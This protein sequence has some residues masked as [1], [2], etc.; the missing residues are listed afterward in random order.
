MVFLL[1]TKL[2][3]TLDDHSVMGL[4]LAQSFFGAIQPQGTTVLVLILV[5]LLF[6]S[7]VLAGA[8]V[9]FFSLTFKDINL[10]K[11]KQQPAYKRIVDL[12]EQPKILLASLLI[13]N[14]FINISIII[15]SN[16]LID[17]M[18]NFEQFDAAWVEF[19]IKVIAVTFLLVLFG[20]IMPKVLATQNNVRFAKDFGGIVYG[21]SYV[22]MG[23][24]KPLVK[25]SDII[26]RKLANKS[27]SAYSLEE[28]DHAID[29]TTNETASENE[30]NILKSI[31]KFR[32]I[33]V[34]QIMKTRMDVSGVDQ[35]I[36]FDQLIEFVREVNYSRIPVY[37][38]DLDEVLGII[39]TKDLVPHLDESTTYN[40]HKL[41]RPPYFVHEQKPIEDLLKEFQSKRIHFAVVVDEFGGTS[42]IV[43]LEDILEE[44]IGEIKDEFDEE[45]SDYK[46]ID[47]NNYIFE[48]R[49]MIQDLCKVMD[50]PTETFDTVKGESDS[51]AGLVLELAGD[52]P[53]PAAILTSGD[54][55]FTVLEVAKN[56][57]QK[58]KVS[59]KRQYTN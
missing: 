49:V 33:T 27:A 54:F 42:G 35:E 34:K 3:V 46:K 8:E 44:I 10:L 12:I 13:A 43:T 40:W 1:G 56:R 58:I 24:S 59:I 32:N 9:A 14:S 23:L 52:F 17:N 31:V 36:S 26:E 7:F 45:D 5:V 21:I 11:S 48:G 51:L 29:L 18:F 53:K 37:K 30:K 55:E 41:L 15:I 57:L 22:V 20:E 6:L 4:Y 50:L 39:H 2:T 16:L 47:D 28:L 19:V 25:Y 38:E